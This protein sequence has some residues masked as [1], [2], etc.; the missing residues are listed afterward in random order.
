MLTNEPY[1]DNIQFILNKYEMITF[2]FINID[3]YYGQQYNETVIHY[4]SVFLKNESSFVVL[5]G[6]EE[7]KGGKL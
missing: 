2:F 7:C 4:Q 6:G 5:T 1:N 3:N